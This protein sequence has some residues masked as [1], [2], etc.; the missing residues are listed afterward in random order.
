MK[1]EAKDKDMELFA[2]NCVRG[3]NY[4]EDY[5]TYSEKSKNSDK[6]WQEFKDEV[7]SELNQKYGK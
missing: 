4:A 5:D 7:K 2:I 6:D 3:K 1:N